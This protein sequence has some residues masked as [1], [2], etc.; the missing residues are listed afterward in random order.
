MP[1]IPTQ[2]WFEVIARKDGRVPVFVLVIDGAPYNWSSGPVRA[3]AAGGSDWDTEATPLISGALEVGNLAGTDID[4]LRGKFG[5]SDLRVTIADIG[6]ETVTS[7]HRGTVTEWVATEKA[8]T[9]ILRRKATLWLGE[10][11]MHEDEYEE[12][13]TGLVDDWD[14]KRNGAVYEVRLRSLLKGWERDIMTEAD[15]VEGTTVARLSDTLLRGN[16]DLSSTDDT[17]NNWTLVF[18]SGADEDSSYVISDYGALTRLITLSGGGSSTYAIGDAFKLFLLNEIVGNPVNIWVRILV[19]DFALAGSIQTNYP[20]TSVTGTPA[21]LDYSLSDIDEDAVKTE[22]DRWFPTVVYDLKWVKQEKANKTFNEQIFRVLGAY[23]LVTPDG[24]FSIRAARP[25]IPPTT[26]LEIVNTDVEGVPDMGRDEESIIN[27]VTI[28]G[29]WNEATDTYQELVVRTTPDA[30]YTEDEL[31]ETRDL[32]I[33]SR[34][35]SSAQNGVSLATALADRILARYGKGGPEVLSLQMGP[36]GALLEAGER[37][38]LTH[39]QLPNLQTGIRGKVEEPFEVTRVSGD[40]QRGRSDVSVTQYY[41][42]GRPGFIAP[43]GTTASYGSATVDDKQ[44]AYVSP[45][46]GNFADDGAPYV[47]I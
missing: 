26:P 35:L 29:D 7:A 45:N 20:I 34:G 47:R 37:V 19:N 8:T 41:V 33:Q 42:G 32:N 13:Y 11:S 46:S 18:T 39:P 23:P 15:N 6:Y 10:A 3:K 38:L 9:R 21:G 5:L 12:I 28:E 4:P 24:K 22:R 17:Y 43:T 40:M 16:R 36:L 14:L 44:Y 31:Q 1:Y 25:Q 2:K 30:R 27:T